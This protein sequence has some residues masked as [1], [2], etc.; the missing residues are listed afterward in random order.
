MVSKAAL[1]RF[2]L[3]ALFLSAF[4]GCAAVSNM[5]ELSTLK[6]MGEEEQA[7]AKIIEREDANFRKIKTA[8]QDRRLQTG[9]KSSKV[10]SEWGEPVVSVPEGKNQRWIYKEK[11]GDWF[12]GAKIYLFF[13]E[14]GLL[15]EWKCVNTACGN[16]TPL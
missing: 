15:T 3:P 4:A 2:L 10:S 13:N 14:N 9:I 6:S 7:K 1:S 11:N 8:I 12:K 5:E 16:E